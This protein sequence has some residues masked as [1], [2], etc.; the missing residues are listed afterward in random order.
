[1]SDPASLSSASARGRG[2]VH[3]E[4]VAAPACI[5]SKASIQRQRYLRP[6]AKSF[7]STA[8]TTWSA[9]PPGMTNAPRRT[10]STMRPS[11]V[12]P[13]TLVL[14]VPTWNFVVSSKPNETMRLSSATRRAA[15]ISPTITI[16]LRIFRTVS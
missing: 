1:M 10:M 16:S 12:S 3:T 14:S 9:V 6:R 15:S 2:P 11:T 4:A 7:F 5:S 8:S 13:C